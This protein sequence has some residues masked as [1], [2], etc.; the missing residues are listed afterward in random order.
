MITPSAAARLIP[1]NGMSVHPSEKEE[2]EQVECRLEN[3][4]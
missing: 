1:E 3:G 2:V 4:G